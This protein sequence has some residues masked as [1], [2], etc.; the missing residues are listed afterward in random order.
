LKAMGAQLSQPLTCKDTSNGRGPAHVWG[1]SCM[2]GWRS[3][4]EDS[5]IAISDFLD[6]VHSDSAVDD[7]LFT[8]SSG[9]ALFGVFDGHGG[10]EVAE[11]CRRHL[12][13]ELKHRLSQGGASSSTS[14]FEE[15]FRDTFHAMD[16]LLGQPEGDRELLSLRKGAA[17]VGTSPVETGLSNALREPERHSAMEPKV[18]SFLKTSIEGDLMQARDRG[19]LTKDEVAQITM[20]LALLKRLE[21]QGKS[22]E[23]HAA[24]RVGCTAVCVLL[25]RD[26]IVCA[27]AGD[28]RAVLCR[29]G[30]A[31]EL[32]QDHKPERAEERRRIEAAGG[33][34]E[35]IH[36]A[37]RVFYRV[38]GNLSLSRAIGDMEFKKSL[39]LGPE[40]Q[41]VCS[42]PDVV[43]MLRA[44]DDEFIVLAC[45]GVW[46]VK[47]SQEVCDFVRDGLRTGRGVARVAEQLLDSC[48]AE[49]PK[50]ANGLG[51][52]N[53]TCI[54]VKLSDADFKPGHAASSA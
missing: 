48:L 38:N 16:D 54:I 18:I 6:G 10:A 32:S 49:D 25:S 53:M 28:S 12:P 36:V 26:T 42:T 30:G 34:I 41:V 45:D 1:C 37:T 46:D 51:G 50:A 7:R 33:R 5:H 14:L 24:D 27:N 40:Q 22:L 23:G 29:A 15:A 17:K 21:A 9:I 35:E 8:A 3:S 43:L 4:M 11:F 39:E 2:Q 20:K 47:T 52:D 13:D 19:A 44:E 31:V